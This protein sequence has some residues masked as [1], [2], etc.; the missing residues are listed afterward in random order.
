MMTLSEVADLLISPE[1]EFLAHGNYVNRRGIR[2]Y[3]VQ[4]KSGNHWC[5]VSISHADRNANRITA[6]ELEDIRHNTLQSAVMIPL[7][8]ISF[9][10]RS[11]PAEQAPINV[12]TNS[13]SVE[14][15]WAEFY[16][17]GCWYMITISH[18][19]VPAYASSEELEMIADDLL[20]QQVSGR[21]RRAW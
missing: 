21:K 12:Y 11:C 8:S 10:L 13:S 7:S 20:R 16:F 6:E 4:V 1:S 5:K 19:D 2:G 18:V 14:G 3:Y 17:E 15:N 9:A